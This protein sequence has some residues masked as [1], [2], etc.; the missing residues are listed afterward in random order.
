MRKTSMIKEIFILRSFACLSIVLLHAIGIGLVTT[1][2]EVSSWSYMT[3]DSINMFLYFGTP[4][5]IFISELLIAYSYKH[6]RLP[7]HFLSKRFKLLFLPFL[8][9]AIFYSIPHAVSSIGDWGIKLFLNVFIGDFHGYFVLIIF[10]FY[11]LHLLLHKQLR[12]WCPKVVLCLSLIINIAYLAIFN[13]ISPP[14][15]LFGVYIWE[16]FYWVPFLGWIFYF[17]LGYYC[18][19]YY[20]EFVRTLRTKKNWVLA[21]PLISTLFLLL[22]YHNG[23][24]L[25]HSSK[26]IDM[27]F[28]TV[29]VSF[30]IFYIATQLKQYPNWLIK[31]S[32]YS[33]GIYLLHFFY[34]E[35]I[36]LVYNW[37]S[38]QLGIVFIILLF[39][40]STIFSII[41]VHLLNK[42]K[43]GKYIVG[44]IGIGYK[45]T[46]K[47]EK[48]PEKK[49]VS[50]DKD[51]SYSS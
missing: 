33:F 40:L 8:F 9:M 5:F 1:S 47:Y 4:M 6:K 17:V 28:H 45:N 18:G 46:T 43:Y 11:L 15:I 51:L 31:I 30:F 39:T 16:R 50:N 22:S 42:W 21:A 14:D 20:E 37:T 10:Q 38:L 35:A 23:W 24:L 7:S 32:Q 19:H 29:A 34:L 26:R 41:T 48:Y 36:N 3:F 25:I 44:Q 12:K 2:N 27:L 49:Q 13:F